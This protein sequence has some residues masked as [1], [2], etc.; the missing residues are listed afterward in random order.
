MVQIRNKLSVQQ[1]E[2]SCPAARE[3]YDVYPST[4]VANNYCFMHG[5]LTGYTVYIYIYMCVYTYINTYDSNS[6][7]QPGKVANL[8]RCQL[9][10]EN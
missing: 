2:I 10:R 9:N 3:R 7:D 4:A 6:K 5:T 8:A 1:V